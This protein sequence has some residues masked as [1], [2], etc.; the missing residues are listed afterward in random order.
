MTTVRILMI[1]Q[2]ED[3]LNSAD[4]IFTKAGMEITRCRSGLLALDLMGRE[5]FD[6]ILI[7]ANLSVLTG[8]DV[9]GF[10]GDHFPDMPWSI[11]GDNGEVGDHIVSMKEMGTMPCRVAQ[12]VGS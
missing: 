3:E 8:A 7:A 10:I 9:A 4:E 2:D 11:M 1:N 12:A 5:R 6:Y